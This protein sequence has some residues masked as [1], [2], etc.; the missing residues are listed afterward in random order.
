MKNNLRIF[1]KKP[2]LIPFALLNLVRD[3]LMQP[4]RILKESRLPLSEPKGTWTSAKSLP[5]W[6]YEFGG[7]KVGDEIYLVG[8]L[9]LPTVYTI[10]RRVEAYRCS[11]DSWHTVPSYPVIIHH[12]SV[13]CL[14]DTLYVV[15]GNGMRITPYSYVFAYDSKGNRWIRKADMPTPRGALGAVVLDDLIYAV[16]GG[17]NKVAR[18]ELEVYDPQ[19]NTW[20]K[21]ASMPTPR[22]HLAAAVAGGHIF[23]LG[24]YKTSLAECSTANE[25]YNP[26]TNKWEK[27]APMPLPVAG[28]AAVGLGDSVFIFGGEQG[29]SVSAEVHEY[30]VKEDKWYRRA[31]M[32]V[33]R[34]ASAAVS[35]GTKI[36]VFGGNYEL[37]GYI[38]SMDHDIFTPG[39]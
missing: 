30:K 38:Y 15:G 11:T 34:Y 6:R 19:K 2:T 33:G 4:D 8:G 29:W 32:P 5:S 7:A 16:G 35:D 14:G 39:T 31:D 12:P 22:E 18:R 27:R 21:L 28:F 37:H 10:T 24:G 20:K 17:T 25:A 23:A 36:H 13:V 9:V 3:A 1:L 26:K